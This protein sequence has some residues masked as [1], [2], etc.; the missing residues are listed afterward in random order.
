MIE[1]DLSW[2]LGPI[3]VP[4][5]CIGIHFDSSTSTSSRWKFLNNWYR[6]TCL[7]I[8]IIIQ[9]VMSYFVNHDWHIQTDEQVNSS[10]GFWVLKLDFFLYIFSNGFGHVIILLD[11]GKYWIPL[12]NTYHDIEHRHHV[13]CNAKIRRLSIIGL[14]YISMLVS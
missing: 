3:L 14:V 4:M 13:Q 5:R 12:L 11:L 2:C 7:A 9:S 6:F 8:N 10:K 1:R